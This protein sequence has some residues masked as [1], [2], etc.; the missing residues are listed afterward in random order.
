MTT[1]L[2]AVRREPA[3]PATVPRHVAIIMDGNGRWAR[4]RG[5]PRVEGH[6]RGVQSLR[7]IVRHAGEIGIEVLTLYSFSSENWSR[8]LEEVSELLNLLRMFIRRDLAELHRSNVRVTVIGERTGLPRDITKLLDEAETTTAANT[9]LRLVVAFN[10]GSRNEIARA[11]QSI[12]AEVAAGRLAVDDIDEAAISARLDTAGI[13]DP[14]VI[15]RTSGEERL[16]NFLLWQAAYSEFVFVDTL[17]PDFKPADLD[18]AL[19]I[20]LARERRFGG[21]KASVGA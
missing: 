1:G 4:A 20:Y 3:D 21:L 16:S 2:E 5:L 17:W 10:Y 6:R 9:G 11:V 19:E 15:I 8:P 13:A 7:D 18:A 14:D 12:A